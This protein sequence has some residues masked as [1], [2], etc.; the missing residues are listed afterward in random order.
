MG[1]TTKASQSQN[2]ESDKKYM[3]SELSEMTNNQIRQ[4]ASDRGYSLTATNKAGLIS[5]FLM[6]QEQVIILEEKLLRDLK[7]DLEEDCPEDAILLLSVQR[8][9]R[10]F[11]RKR[12]YP[13]S[14]SEEKIL[15][16]MENC[17]DCIYDLTV[18]KLNK[19]GNEFEVSHNENGVNQ[20][21]CSE[22]EIYLNHGIFS[23]PTMF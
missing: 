18:F 5:E 23:Y 19:R 14:F 8:A 15:N 11:K 22:S 2:V 20:T 9:I 12:N 6:W 17:Y 3:E 13:N 7:I 4:L 10:S 16:D 1:Y 21:W